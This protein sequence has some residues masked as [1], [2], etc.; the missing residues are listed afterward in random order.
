[1][2]AGKVKSRYNKDNYY[3]FTNKYN[4][5]IDEVVVDHPELHMKINSEDIQLEEIYY[6]CLTTHVNCKLEKEIPVIA[7]A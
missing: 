3:M 2:N 6:F 1:M 7:H 4:H 5:W